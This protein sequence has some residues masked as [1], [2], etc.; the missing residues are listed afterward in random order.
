MFICAVQKAAQ[1]ERLFALEEYGSFIMAVKGC[2]GS[3]LPTFESAPCFPAGNLKERRAIPPRFREC[4]RFSRKGEHREKLVAK[5]D[6]SRKSRS[7]RVSER[8]SPLDLAASRAASAT[9]RRA[10]V[11]ML[12]WLL[13]P[14]CGR[15]ITT[16]SLFTITYYLTLGGWV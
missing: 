9:T 1:R 14:D 4:A 7:D 6:F 2:G 13:F 10:G 12:I 16:Y 11:V 15:Y 8:E 5:R 3:C